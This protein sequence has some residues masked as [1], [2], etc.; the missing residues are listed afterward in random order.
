MLKENRIK[1]QKC[2]QL[3]FPFRRDF[4]GHSAPGKT[5]EEAIFLTGNKRIP[6]RV[7]DENL[8]QL[9][10]TIAHKQIIFKYY[11]NLNI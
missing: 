8:S 11:L 5:G 7:K 2:Q 9:Q 3:D 10:N 4:L 1:W 6:K